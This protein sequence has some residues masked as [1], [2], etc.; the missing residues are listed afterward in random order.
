MTKLLT[1]DKARRIAANIAKLPE[2]TAEPPLGGHRC[3]PVSLSMDQDVVVI[4]GRSRRM[5]R[6]RHHMCPMSRIDSLLS[7]VIGQCI[8]VNIARRR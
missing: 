7:V 5:L 1:K 8:D 3:R 4:I 2:L 6:A